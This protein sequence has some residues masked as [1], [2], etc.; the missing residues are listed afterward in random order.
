MTW[1]LGGSWGASSAL[2]CVW[3]PGWERVVTEETLT[4][5][6]TLS[7]APGLTGPRGGGSKGLLKSEPT[8]CKL[9]LLPLAK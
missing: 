7:L 5:P 9:A 1:A 6:Q 4:A 3:Q 2:G 8:L